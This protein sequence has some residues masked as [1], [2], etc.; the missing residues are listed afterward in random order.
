[1]QVQ[2]FVKGL[3]GGVLLVSLINY[4]NFFCGIARVSRTSY[5]PSSS[6]NAVAWL[7][8]CGR[9]LSLVFQGLTTATGIAVVEE[10]LFRS[11]LPEE[12]AVDLGYFRGVIISGLA[13]SLSQ[14]FVSLSLDVPFVPF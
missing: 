1:M 7:K 11:W 5:L 6:S 9:T 10:L 3:L 12:I 13:F 8:V 2:N 4:V 14:R